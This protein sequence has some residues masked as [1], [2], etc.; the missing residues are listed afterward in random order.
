MA[1]I[2]AQILNLG[3]AG[4]VVALNP[5]DWLTMSLAKAD[6]SGAYLGLPPNL[7][8]RVAAVASVTAGHILA[9]APSTGAAF[10]DRQAVTVE[11]GYTGSGFTQ[12]KATLLCEARGSAFVRDP[13]L[14]AYGALPARLWAPHF[15]PRFLRERGVGPTRYR[16]RLR[17][18]FSMRA[19]GF[20]T[21]PYRMHRP[22]PSVGHPC[23]AGLL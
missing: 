9:F 11:A 12:N 6:T 21:R 22:L 16:Q 7:A 23:Q 13:G 15:P 10:A 18:T 20:C 17:L 8:T 2:A 1:R 19:T 3:G 14:V 5:T 4:V